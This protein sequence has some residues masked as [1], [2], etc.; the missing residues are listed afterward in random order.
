MGKRRLS[1][2]PAFRSDSKYA[3]F[4]KVQ[5]PLRGLQT[6]ENAMEHRI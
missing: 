5:D 2:Q 4:F 6:H 1:P 3:F